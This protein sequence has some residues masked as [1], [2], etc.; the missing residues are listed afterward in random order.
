MHRIFTWLFSVF[1]GGCIAGAVLW[2]T[3]SMIEVESSILP[4]QTNRSG[5]ELIGTRHQ[6]NEKL[7]ELDQAINSS[8]SCKT[9]NDCV[10]L[11]D[12]NLTFSQCFISVQNEKV[13]LVSANLEEFKKHCRD[14]YNTGCGHMFAYATCQKD[15]CSVDY[16]ERASQRSVQ[17][18]QEQTLKS[19]DENFQVEDDRDDS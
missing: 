1:V 7:T 19:I 17:E 12:G 8:K 13:E 5:V 2:V 4:D 14:S 9:D 3:A 11:M 18:L 10:L 16:I 15:I 6:C